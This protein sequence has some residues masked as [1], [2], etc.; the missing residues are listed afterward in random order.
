MNFLIKR[1]ILSTEF[2]ISYAEAYS[3]ADLLQYYFIKIKVQPSFKLKNTLFYNN[4]ILF[5]FTH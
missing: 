4:T 5:C 1:Y 3:T 2:F